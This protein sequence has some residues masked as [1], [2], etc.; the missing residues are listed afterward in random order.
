MDT[1]GRI[2]PLMAKLANEFLMDYAQS[3]GGNG[4]SF[5]DVAVVSFSPEPI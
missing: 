5:G 1:V 4:S 2:S 3:C